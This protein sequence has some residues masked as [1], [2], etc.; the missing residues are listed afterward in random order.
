MLKKL[1]KNDITVEL[2]ETEFKLEPKEKDFHTDYFIFQIEPLKQI[3]HTLDNPQFF[4]H[5]IL[6]GEEGFGKRSSIVNLI[7]K[8]YSEK[9]KSPKK[10]FFRKSNTIVTD[11]E[12]KEGLTPLFDPDAETTPVIFDPTPSIMSLV[13]IPT[14][15]KYYPGNLIKASGGY[16]VLPIDKLIKDT[17]TYEI[18]K[19]SIL[20]ESIDFINLPELQ[21][22]QALD[23][24]LPQFPVDA[25]IILIGEEHQYEQLL[26]RDP[27]LHEVFKVKIDLETEG[28]VS[29]KN[30]ARFSNLIDV[31]SL[32]ELPPPHLSA[33]KR[34]F[35]EALKINENKTKFSLNITKIKA[36]YE[37]AM[38]FAKSKKEQKGAFI[39]EADI[40][41][42]LANIEKRE[43]TYKKRYYEDLK[44]GIYNLSFTGKRVG[45]INGLSIFMP[46]NQKQEFGQ[47]NVISSRAIMGGGNFINIEREVNL[48]GDFHDKGVFV[49]QSFLKGLFPGFASLGVDIS[50]LFEQSHHLIDGDS[51]SVA[52]LIATISAL[53]GIEVPCNVAVTGSMSQYGE[54]MAVGAI[55]QKIESWFSITKLLGSPREVYSVYIPISNS[56]DLI[57]S[58]ELRKA[59]GE[60]KF[61]IVSYSH[62]N[63]ILPEILKTPL[64][65]IEK[66]GKHSSESILR[67]IEDRLER[68]KEEK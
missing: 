32:P 55:N 16:L 42:G 62:I 41:L 59:V 18:L 67:K 28:E 52:E 21:F 48:S 10:F 50:I 31:L 2:K 24:M 49:L 53:S 4:K 61:Q 1:T 47:V 46:F 23:R 3:R 13:G 68:K 11:P 15:K 35:E 65:K 37:E 56:K 8:E 25:R 54:A 36:I 57:L 43:S 40:E 60:N 20:S 22:Y 66:D 26:K 45:R 27:N 14:D 64:G 17:L 9:I 12:I 51:A 6:T 38:T 7:K 58:A 30:L 33:K 5:F 44:N 29:K 63:E 19:A 39:T 34:I